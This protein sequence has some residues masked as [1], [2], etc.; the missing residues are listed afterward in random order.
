MWI[1]KFNRRKLGQRQWETTERQQVPDTVTRSI[2]SRK[3]KTDEAARR[4]SYMLVWGKIAYTW[5]ME[6]FRVGLLSSEYSDSEPKRITGTLLAASRVLYWSAQRNWSV[7]LRSTVLAQFGTA[8]LLRQ[9]SS[10]YF[11]TSLW[12]RN[13]LSGPCIL[14]L[15]LFTDE[16]GYFSLRAIVIWI[17]SCD[18]EKQSLIQCT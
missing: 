3:H 18:A 17:N 6:L 14:L 5:V 10:F 4:Q 16:S 11:A 13:P 2:H 9:S 8:F 15:C 12:T 1:A 7:L